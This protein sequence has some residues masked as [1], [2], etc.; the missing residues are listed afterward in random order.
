MTK[1]NPTVSASSYLHLIIYLKQFSSS[2]MYLNK[3]K[4]IVWL[5]SL[6]FMFYGETITISLAFAFNLHC[7]IFEPDYKNKNLLPFAFQLIR[8]AHTINLHSLYQDI[9]DLVQII[10]HSSYQFCCHYICTN[11]VIF[12]ELS[13]LLNVRNHI[14]KAFS[15]L[16]IQ[17]SILSISSFSNFW[18]T[19]NLKKWLSRWTSPLPKPLMH[20]CYRNRYLFSTSKVALI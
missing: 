19:L 9:I 15:L 13:N 17:Y 5:L 20:N 1:I 2:G 8:F 18:V 6:T 12:L 3:Y 10:E 11:R 4:F 7:N 16:L 14:L